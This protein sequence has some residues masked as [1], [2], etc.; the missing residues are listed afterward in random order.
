MEEV[1]R[2]KKPN[3]IA[4]AYTENYVGHKGDRTPGSLI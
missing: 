2:K 3:E 4:E 1:G